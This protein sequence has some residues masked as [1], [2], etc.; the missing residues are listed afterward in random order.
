[1]AGHNSTVGP[2]HPRSTSNFKA[3]AAPHDD[4]T[5]TSGSASASFV[6]QH[7]GPARPARGVPRQVR[8]EAPEERIFAE[9]VPE[10]RGHGSADVTSPR[11]RQTSGLEGILGPASKPWT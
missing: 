10:R 6:H 4:A 5:R 2:V 1:M 9:R 7:I 11:L 3:T 8:Q